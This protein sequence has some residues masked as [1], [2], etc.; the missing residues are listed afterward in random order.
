[1]RDSMILAAWFFPPASDG[2]LLSVARKPEEEDFTS[3]IPGMLEH[4]ARD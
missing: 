3:F 4:F 1:M 2:F